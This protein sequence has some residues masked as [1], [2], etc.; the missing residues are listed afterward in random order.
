MTRTSRTWF[1]V[2]VGLGF[3]VT[4]LFLPAGRLDYWQGWIYLGLSLAV[5]LVTGYVLR[6]NPGLIAERLYP[7]RGMKAWDKVYF[8]LSAPLYFGALFLAGLDAGRGHWTGKFPSG[9]YAVGILLFLLG[10]FLFLWAKKA[11]S[12]FSSVVRIQADRGQ[13]VCRA[14]PYRYV[15]HPGY[16][17][18]I[19]FG[20]ATPLILGSAWALVPQSLAAL[21]LVGRTALEDSTLKKELPGYREYARA[22]PCR[23][24]PRVW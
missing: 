15:R 7:G 1:Q 16:L 21:L 4:A 14:G 19:L 20:L 18:G 24:V 6:D 3:L 9:L 13:T 8:G 22:V 2:V 23:L 11:N 17:A 10:Q 12:Y 5:L